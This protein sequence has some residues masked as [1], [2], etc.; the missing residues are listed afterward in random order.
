MKAYQINIAPRTGSVWDLTVGENENHA[1][2]EFSKSLRDS[3]KIINA[4]IAC[5]PECNI[6]TRKPKERN[7]EILRTLRNQVGLLSKDFYRP[8]SWPKVTNRDYPYNHKSYVKE[9]WLETSIY[10]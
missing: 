4:K 9:V 10:K 7:V 5:G 6:N 1:L 8:N 3:I 2:A